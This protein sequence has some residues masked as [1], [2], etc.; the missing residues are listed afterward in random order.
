MQLDPQCVWADIQA[1]KKFSPLVHNI[2]NYVVMEST[3][4][5]LLAIGASPIMAH[6][7]DEI[8]DIVKIA[9]SLVLNIG[10]LCPAW[11]QAMIL[12]LKAAT[13]K[14]IPVILDPVGAGASCYRTK[15]VQSILDH[16]TVT[17]IRGNASEIASLSG[18]QVQTKG[19]DSLLDPADCQSQ[20]KRLASKNRCV[21]WMSGQTDLITDGQSCILISNGHPMMS[22]VTGMGCMATAITGAFLTVN[23]N[24]FLG[25]AHASLVM[26]IVGEMTAEKC[27]GPGSFKV[28]FIDS[29]YSLS[30][31]D[32]KEQYETVY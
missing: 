12:A 18:D 27:R 15:M 7:L 2:T 14:G 5:A 28:E 32:I 25:S 1:I 17:V 13:S 9:N 20:A 31:S 30:L 4:N 3:A 8:D 21:V 10:T 19:V 26:G 6:A 24:A 23:P 29:L 16:G 11:I 22:K